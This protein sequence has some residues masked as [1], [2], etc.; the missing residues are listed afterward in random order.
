MRQHV[1]VLQHRRELQRQRL[2]QVADGAGR[3]TLQAGEDGTAR[4][5]T[6]RGERAVEVDTILHH[7]VK[8]MRPG[9]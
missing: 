2:G 9:P 1:E 6:E 3:L 8:Y 7:V 5:V 4:R